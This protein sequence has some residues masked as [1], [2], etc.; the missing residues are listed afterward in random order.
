MKPKKLTFVVTVENLMVK[1]KKSAEI[2]A[3]VAEELASCV[4]PF[5]RN[6]DISVTAIGSLMDD[7]D[8]AV[9]LPEGVRS[10]VEEALRHVAEQ[11]LDA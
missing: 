3:T 1:K 8:A 7:D 2:A 9:S 6:C 10:I 5:V 11:K 4:D